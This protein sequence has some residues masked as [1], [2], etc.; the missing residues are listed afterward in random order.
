MQGF[1][2]VLA[3]VAWLAMLSGPAALA[4]SSQPAS[5][6][7]LQG[8]AGDLLVESSMSAADR[9]IVRREIGAA[10][11]RML[12]FF[13]TIM[14]R[15][16]FVAC[17]TEACAATDRARGVSAIT[18]GE[19]PIRRASLRPTV[20]SL[21][22]EWAHAELALRMGGADRVDLLPRWFQEGIAMAVSEEPAGNEDDWRAIVKHAL[23]Y[24]S[25][26]ELATRQDW[27]IAARTYG[28]PGRADP[29]HLRIVYTR[30]GKEVRAWLER[31]RPE[32]A[33]RLIERVRAGEPFAQ[34]YAS[35]GGTP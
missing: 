10:R 1:W 5:A 18:F 31:A 4:Q 2:R 17:S 7:Q 21:A 29:F 32:G 6:V 27:L 12:K 24:P 9:E 28:P 35:I 20:R 25:L 26:S 15:P 16:E 23:P 11:L 8:L 34:T 19:A 13:G 33:L 14:S 22:H 30:A 3:A